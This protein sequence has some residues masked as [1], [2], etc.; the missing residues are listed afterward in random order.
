MKA[1]STMIVLAFTLAAPLVSAGKIQPAFPAY[2]DT[3]DSIKKPAARMNFNTASRRGMK[4]HEVFPQ[5]R[6]NNDEPETVARPTAAKPKNP[7][8]V[9]ADCGCGSGKR[10]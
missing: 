4:D 5:G 9:G 7:I 2:P 1:L 8:C 3:A 10:R 6:N